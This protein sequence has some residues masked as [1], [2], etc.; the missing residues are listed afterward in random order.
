MPS[1]NPYTDAIFSVVSEYKALLKDAPKMRV[2]DIMSERSDGKTMNPL[3]R[4]LED[5]GMTEKDFRGMFDG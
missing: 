3:A 5:Y 4:W 1:K 2:P